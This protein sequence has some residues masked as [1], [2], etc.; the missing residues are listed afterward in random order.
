MRKIHCGT[1][2]LATT[3]YSFV[4]PSNGQKHIGYLDYAN[5]EQ[6]SLFSFKNGAEY[7]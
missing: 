5:K 2:R 6:S 1:L 7:F 3:T 4:K